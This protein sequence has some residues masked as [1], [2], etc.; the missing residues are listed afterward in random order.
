MLSTRES[1]EILPKYNGY[2]NTEYFVVKLYIF[3]N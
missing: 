3:I 2:E 1:I